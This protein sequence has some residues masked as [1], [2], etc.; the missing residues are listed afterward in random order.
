MA[1][2]EVAIGVWISL[3]VSFAT[4]QDGDGGTVAGEPPGLA[5]IRAADLRERVQYL[6]DDKLEGRAAGTKGNERAG[7]YIAAHF[8]QLG[9]RRLAMRGRS[10]FQDFNADSDRYKEVATR[11]VVG[12]LEGSDALLK[13]EVIV[14][15]AHYDHV[16]IGRFGSRESARSSLA[17]KIHNGADDNASGTAGMMEL[18]EA[19]AEAPP[20]RSLLFLAFS[21]EELGLLGSRHYCN[22][23]LVPL[24]RTI[25]MF[26][27]DMIGR[28]EDDYLFVGGTGTSPVWGPLIERHLEPAGFAIERGPGGRAP[29]D[30]TPFYERGMPVLFFFTNVHV[31]YH[32]VSDEADTINYGSAEKI[33]RAAYA[34]IRDVADAPARPTF[35]SAEGNGMPASMNKLLEEPSR[36][37]DLARKL[38]GR[39]RDRVDKQ[40]CGRLGFAP[41]TAQRGELMIG[42]VLVDG[43]AARAGLEPGDVV[44]KVGERAVR[45]S[46]DVAD[47]LDKVAAGAEVTLEQRR[48][49]RSE[50]VLVEVG[51]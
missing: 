16:G 4:A 33:V 37:A 2:I 12:L 27:F 30:N 5:T 13:D 42:E 48:A 26:N 43:P 44:L 14:I 10:W 41:A 32:R 46:K 3:T 9:L 11:N 18:A 8:R 34:L 35:Q 23:P 19:F 7:E 50:Q 29:S 51:R 25:A 1:R 22:E 20:R 15:G 17:D 21:A 28:S 38:R 6:A 36:A 47:A 31:D 39:A 24:E 45:T 49:G 40:G